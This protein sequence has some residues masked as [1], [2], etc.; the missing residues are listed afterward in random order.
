M[1]TLH[2]SRDRVKVIFFDELGYLKANW[3]SYTSDVDQ[4]RLVKFAKASAVP[5]KSTENTPYTVVVSRNTS[6]TNAD[7]KNKELMIKL[8]ADCEELIL[9]T[10]HHVH[11]VP[12]EKTSRR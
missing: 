7:I 5:Q 2:G 4:R 3:S 6:P 1:A 8:Y 10:T 9:T 12:A 11:V